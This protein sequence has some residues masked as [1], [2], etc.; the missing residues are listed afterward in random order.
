MRNAWLFFRF[1]ISWY[2]CLKVLL[3]SFFGW[4]GVWPS[5]AW[6]KGLYTTEEWAEKQKLL[7]G[8]W[9]GETQCGKLSGNVIEVDKNYIKFWAEYEGKSSWEP[10]FINN[11]TGCDAN[12]HSLPLRMS[13]PEMEPAGAT[14]FS[15]RGNA[16][17]EVGYRPSGL[18]GN[19]LRWLLDL[20][21]ERGHFRRLGGRD[22]DEA[23]GLHRVVL[24]SERGEPLK[25]GVHVFWWEVNGKVLFVAECSWR[26]SPQDMD[27][28]SGSLA[29]SE[30]GSF[31][32]IYFSSSLLGD[33][34]LM[35]R[36]VRSFFIANLKINRGGK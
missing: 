36:Q 4:G 1:A 22:F 3:I 30:W 24:E 11:K 8:Y 23:L 27:D 26:V 6:E 18:R 34:N 28:C 5:I 9:N 12:L 10:G 21:L 25:V 29:L 16:W 7:Y 31:A 19:D 17:I 13:W 15:K 2:L 14:Y 32:R 33:W 20:D 35:V